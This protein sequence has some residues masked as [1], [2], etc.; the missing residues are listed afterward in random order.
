MA[1]GGGV[2]YFVRSN[3]PDVYYARTTLLFGQSFSNITQQAETF[4]A[5]QDLIAVYTGLARRDKTLQPVIDK[6]NLGVSVEQLNQRL[7]ITQVTDLP[8]MEVYVAD[9]DPVRA[10]DIA[11]N[12]AQEIID[13]SPNQEF[14]Q[15]VEFRR[16]Q[17]R[18]LAA[19]ITELQTAYNDLLAKGATLTSAF[20]IAQN[21]NE[22]QATL[23]T[24][25]S[26]QQLYADMSAGLPETGNFIQIYEFATA[27][28]TT[29]VSGSMLSVALAAAAGL[30]LAVGT[31]VLIAFL[32]DRLQW[33]ENIDEIVG[34]KVLGPLG[35][36]PTNKLPLYVSTYSDSIE[37]EVLRQL[38]SKIVL[39]AGG[40]MPGVL[41]V[42]S[43]DSG[44]GKSVT[45][46]NLALATAESGLRTL[47]IDGDMRKGNLHE[48][49]R[50]PNVMGLSDI[51]AGRDDIHLLL[52]RALLDSGH[53][54]LTILT[55]GRATTDPT[56]LLSRPRFS[57]VMD[58]LKSQFDAIV[59]D[60]V[61][62]IGGTDSAFLADRSDGLLIVLH[63]Q[64]TTLRGLKRT[65]LSLR[66]GHDVT[67]YGLVFNRVALQVTSSYSQPYYKRTLAISPDK[68][69][70]EML[71]ASKKPGLFR[72]NK[73]IR[74]AADGGRYY[75]VEAASVQL[76]VSESIMK[77]WIKSGYIKTERFRRKDWIAD[78]EIS[79]LLDRLPRYEYDLKSGYQEPTISKKPPGTRTS[80]KIREMLGGQREA[81]LAA[82][83]ESSPDD[84]SS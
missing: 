4:N 58:T 82:A 51:L 60:S 2:G 71:K 30:L 66:Q 24:L 19:Q 25:Q 13:Q 6:M 79:Q 45:S 35:M 34:V 31:I 68:L 55:C 73:H 52:S 10:A 67:I 39:A 62:T 42:T 32:D 63:G 83:R 69:N 44:D 48:F 29:V 77:E 50:L 5:M 28:N 80:G 59:I 1:L 21:R 70:E 84:K 16:Q 76:G 18:Q 61:P 40:A 23:E 37:S 54:N 7:N 22:T 27:Q 11:N 36:V 3:Q 56:A 57:A 53:E 8:L 9:T 12:L 65:L 17:A 26:I 74:V 43:Y 78:V 72:R 20:E 38:R 41:T 33:Q 64:R 75:S 49:F 47:L 15:D 14:S 46:A 81:M